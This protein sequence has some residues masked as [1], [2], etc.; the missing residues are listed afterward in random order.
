M[1]A[2]VG[3]EVQGV[4]AVHEDRGIVAEVGKVGSVDGRLVAQSRGAPGPTQGV[5][6]VRGVVKGEARVINCVRAASHAG[7]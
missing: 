3:A 1:V 4:G 5:E 2:E 7:T 6:V